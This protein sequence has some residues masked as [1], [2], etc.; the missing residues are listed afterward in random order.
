MPKNSVAISSIWCASSKITTSYGGSTCASGQAERSARS[1]KNRWWF[2]TMSCASTARRRMPVT[3]QRSKNGQRAPSRV[4]GVAETSRQSGESSGSSVRSARSPV[5]VF[6]I[7]ATMRS[8][9]G[10]GTNDACRVCCS[11]RRRHR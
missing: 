2:T 1:A 6:A 3:K 4:S 11:R 5:V 8:S 10:V 9:S 7:Q